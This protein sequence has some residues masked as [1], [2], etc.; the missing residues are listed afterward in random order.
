MFTGLVET[1][2]RL[3]LTA[4]LESG[5]KMTFSHRFKGLE[6]GESI[7]VNG[8]CLTVVA[9]D[10][11]KFEVELSGETLQLTTLGDL[12]EGDVVNM[13]RAL[14]AGDRLGGHMVTGHVDGIAQVT[15]VAPDGEMTLVQLEAP[16]SL[17]QYIA[18]K[19]SLTVEGVSLTVNAVDGC[20]VDLLIIPHTQEVT[21]LG[22]LG[23]GS[24]V[25]IEVDLIARYVARLLEVRA[26]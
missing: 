10:D 3:L 22:R 13:E 21:T 19:G 18:R 1:K 25:N 6:L 15:K 14:R 9:F 12:K 2:N 11:A 17:A 8:A 16:E 24:S 4:P 7:A 23:A 5:K 20:K 26:E